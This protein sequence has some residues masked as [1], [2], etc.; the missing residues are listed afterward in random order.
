MQSGRSAN[1]GCALYCTGQATFAA[2]LNEPS[3]SFHDAMALTLIGGLGI[4]KP[5]GSKMQQRPEALHAR[6]TDMNTSG[7]PT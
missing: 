4:A 6:A 3:C 1:M 2:L 5:P 7:T